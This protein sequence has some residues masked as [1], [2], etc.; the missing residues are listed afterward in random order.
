MVTRA[1]HETLHESR[2]AKQFS[3]GP[4]AR[5]SKAP[6]TFRASEVSGAFEKRDPGLHYVLQTLFW[7]VTQHFL[8]HLTLLFSVFIFFIIL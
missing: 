5:F 3:Q 4:G 2:S 8:F 6:E 7:L 1:L